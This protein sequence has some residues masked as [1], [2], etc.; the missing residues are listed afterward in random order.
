M[1]TR[2][3][4]LS[5]CIPTYN[6]SVHLA[7]CLSSIA[8]NIPGSH[9]GV[10]VCVSDNGSTDDTREVVEQAAK[11][12]RI[13]YSRNSANLGYAPNLLRVIEMAESEFVWVIGDDDMLMPRAVERVLRLLEEQGEADF[14]YVNANHLTADY[15]LSF[16]QPFSLANLP[17][18][19]TRFSSRQASGPLDFFDLIDPR[20]SSDFLGGIFLSVFRR[21]RW[22]ANTHVLNPAALRDTRTFSH[23]DNTFPNIKV[24]A[25]AFSQARA[26]FYAEPVTVCLIGAR[27]WAAM[28]S[29]MRSVYL[30]DALREYRKNGLSLARYA[31]C[32]NAALRHFG[33]DLVRMIAN[34]QE[35]GYPFQNPLRLVVRH[36]LYP[37]FYLSFVY[38]FFTGG[39]WR[40]LKNT[41]GAG[42]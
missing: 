29:L 19:M 33:P 28:A 5:I 23:F 30:L 3:H 24:F 2:M 31:Y 20:I 18:R 13:K 6:R 1:P 15:V 12:V 4:K 17:A 27:E 9:P 11:A 22:L 26:Y 34:R 39:V 14:F 40:R 7:N 38:P 10:Q 8:A 41:L 37:N 25:H 21:D 42:T 36:V 16:P 32:K 35:S